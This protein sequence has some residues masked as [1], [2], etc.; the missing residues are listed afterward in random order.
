MK[1]GE[2]RLQGGL[3]VGAGVGRDAVEFAAI[4]G[5]ENDGFFES[6]A[7]AQFIGGA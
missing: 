3:R 7:E 5:G 2:E 1:I 6:A 4:A